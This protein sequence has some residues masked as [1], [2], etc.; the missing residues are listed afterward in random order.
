MNENKI[1]Q[2]VSL[3]EKEL[4][5]HQ[6]SIIEKRTDPNET[7]YKSLPICIIDAVFSIG[8]KYQ[9]VEKATNSFFN[10]FNLDISRTLPVENEYTISSFINDMDTFNSFE[11]A[12]EKGFNNRQRTSTT[13]GI[14]KAE[15]CYRVAEAFKKH[16]I[17]TLDDFNSYPN[18]TAL[19]L[20]ILKVQGQGSGIM[21]KYLYMLAGKTNEVKPDRHMVNFMKKVFPSLSMDNKDHQEIKEIMKETVLILNNQYPQL[22]E[23]FL[24]VLIWEHMR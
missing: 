24:D 4:D 6:K 20:D 16:N 8:V 11:E 13:N 15:A 23:R 21:L 22:T 14:L 12:A 10:Y 19:D 2:F 18:K 9:S 7:F 5:L 3:C 1:E 17:N